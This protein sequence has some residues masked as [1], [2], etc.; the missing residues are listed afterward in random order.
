MQYRIFNH[1]LNQYW[2]VRGMGLTTDI[3]L[4]GIYS[5]FDAKAIENC[6]DLEAIR[7]EHRHESHKQ[8]TKPVAQKKNKASAS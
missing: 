3:K 1:K 6:P 5:A 7:V 4:A 8:K 2:A